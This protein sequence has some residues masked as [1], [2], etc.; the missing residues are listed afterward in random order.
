MAHPTLQD[1]QVRR[2]EILA[3]AARHGARDV[4][5]FG[6]T[7]RGDDR[8]DSDVDLLVRFDADRSLLDHGAL[9]AD[10]EDVLGCRVDVV[11]ERALKP[12]FRQRALAE[13]V[14]L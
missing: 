2:G 14:A 9:L 11:S 8:P 4:R 1:L 6:S 3:L 7:A 5:V 12:R 10:L 13:A